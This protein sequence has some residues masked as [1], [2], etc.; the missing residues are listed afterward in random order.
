MTDQ[1]GAL[2]AL[3]DRDGAERDECFTAFAA[4][5]QQDALVMDK[6][7]ML[8]ASS[9]LPGTL[10][11]VQAAMQ[12]PA[13][14]LKNPNKARALIGSF[15]ANMALFHAAD[16]SGYRFLADQVLALD[17]INPQVASR[18]VNAFRRLKSWSRRV[19]R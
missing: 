13:F 8:V 2:M 18:I 5:W 15:G 7:F 11:H 12:H 14:T 6:F 1:M 4:R 19:R 3:R 16:G 17:A 10:E 9:Q